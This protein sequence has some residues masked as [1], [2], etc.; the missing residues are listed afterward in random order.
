M[1]VLKCSFPECTFAT[2]DVDV[3]AAVL[4]L[5]IHA[6]SHPAT[7][8]QPAA[9]VS[10]GPK[11]VR[12]TVKLNS[13]PEE[14]NAFTRRWE[15]YKTGSGISDASGPGQLLE[16]TSEEL[17][18]IVLRAH[19]AFTSKRLADAILLLCELAVVPVALGV[20]RS[21]LSAMIQ[22]DEPIRTFAARVQGKAET[23][24]FTTAY[25]GTCSGCQAIPRPHLLYRRQDSRRPVEWHR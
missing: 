1:V 15:T 25:A 17:G 9:T 2:E 19:P 12:P 21:E 22:D 13:T 18:N 23:C 8:P 16:C 24:E 10:R 6:R 3:T 5:E 11:L 20:L 4:L 14:W 7:A